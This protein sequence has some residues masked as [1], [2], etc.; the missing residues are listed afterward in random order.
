MKIENINIE[1]TPNKYILV[2]SAIKKLSIK[3]VKD[4]LKFAENNCVHFTDD[5]SYTETKQF[6]KYIGVIK[7]VDVFEW[8]IKSSFYG[9]PISTEKYY[10]DIKGR[11]IDYFERQ[12]IKRK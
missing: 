12:K 5:F 10:T 1:T 9:G 2:K 3:G 11:R 4:C 6:C 8:I 7:G